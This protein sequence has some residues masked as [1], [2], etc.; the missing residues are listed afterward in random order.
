VW[1]HIVEYD[2]SSSYGS[3]NRAAAIED[4][5]VEHKTD[6]IRFESFIISEQGDGPR[7]EKIMRHLAPQLRTFCRFPYTA[8]FEQM[9]NLLDGLNLRRVERLDLQAVSTKR[10][11]RL[12]AS[13]SFPNLRYL[14]VSEDEP[15][16]MDGPEWSPSDTLF[17]VDP[18]RPLLEKI[19]ARTGKL[20]V[21][22]VLLT[23]LSDD[24]GFVTDA[25]KKVCD[26][27]AQT[28]RI[29][30]FAFS[31]DTLGRKKFKTGWHTVE[32]IG[33]VVGADLSDSKNWNTL[34][35]R[36]KSAF[37]VD[38]TGFRIVNA[39]IWQR[40][41]MVLTSDGSLV[42]PPLEQVETLF[43]TVHPPAKTSVASRI[44]CFEIFLAQ[45]IQDGLKELVARNASGAKALCEWV[46]S[47]ITIEMNG[48]DLRSA[49]FSHIALGLMGYFVLCQVTGQS[50]DVIWPLLSAAGSVW[51]PQQPLVP[52]MQSLSGYF[53]FEGT[54]PNNP[55]ARNIIESKQE[56]KLDLFASMGPEDEPL[57]LFLR[58]NWIDDF[59]ALVQHGDLFD[60]LQLHPTLKVPLI[61]FVILHPSQSERT[62]RLNWRA[63]VTELLP[64]L[65]NLYDEHEEALRGIQYFP[66][67]HA[68]LLLP[69]LQSER[70]AD[71]IK[72]VLMLCFHQDLFADYYEYQLMAASAL[73]KRDWMDIFQAFE[74]RFPGS[75]HQHAFIDRVVAL[76]ESDPNLDMG[77]STFIEA[78]CD[79][80]SIAPPVKKISLTSALSRGGNETRRR[81]ALNRRGAARLSKPL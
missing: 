60:P 50:T 26:A 80:A 51:N 11:E 56:V 76:I 49:E 47:Q 64:V 39:T 4:K 2:N 34:P 18:I 32:W 67:G 14:A 40:L 20:E 69:A 75:E 59:L 77:E 12:F 38:I 42:F 62:Q 19:A 65:L 66:C 63:Q 45:P 27:N 23:N 72:R 55:M 16:D 21:F 53:S 17:D 5:L 30:D 22:R 57:L 13:S 36:V 24:S 79:F 68:K 31:N 54:I 58:D 3:I 35:D 10:L 1:N 41:L 9:E 33:K 7:L 74:E 15:E 81:R 73:S 52:F 43:R 46:K 48:F 28:V 6:L 8:Y 70:T 71:T 25:I 78:F 61:L 44:K 37:G 29:L